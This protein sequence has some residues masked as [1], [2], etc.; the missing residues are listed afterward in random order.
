MMTPLAQPRTAER[1]RLWSV[2][3]TALWLAPQPFGRHGQST[4]LA[5][6][7]LSPRGDGDACGIE[8]HAHRHSGPARERPG[9]RPACLGSK[10]HVSD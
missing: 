9:A 6:S 10:H 7:G 5:V 3:Q 1:G 8:P 2:L 4:G